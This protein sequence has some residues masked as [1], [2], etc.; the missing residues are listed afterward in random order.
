MKYFLR[1][2]FLISDV[3]KSDK[4]DFENLVTGKDGQLFD[5]MPFLSDEVWFPGFR[6]K[7]GNFGFGF[8][9]IKQADVLAGLREIYK[10]HALEGIS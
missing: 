6:K 2:T 5:P 3:V 4:P 7:Q 10:A 8:N 1:A 9:V